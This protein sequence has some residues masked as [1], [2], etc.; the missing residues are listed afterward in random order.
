MK[1]VN[2]T[3][4]SQ[5]ISDFDATK[6]TIQIKKQNLT[7]FKI[8]VAFHKECL[9]YVNGIGGSYIKFL[10]YL[11]SKLEPK[12]I[13]ELGNLTG[14]STLA[15]YDA[16]ERYDACF[17]TIDLERDQRFCPDVMF[18]DPKIQFLFGDVLDVDI[19][20]KVPM[21]IDFLFSDTVH[22]Y[23]QLASEFDV[24]QHLLADRA[25]FAIDD[26]HLNDKGIFWDSLTYDKWDLTVTE[27][28]HLSGWGI[29][30]FERK[31]TLSDEER[32]LRTTEAIAR[33]WKT[34]YSKLIIE[35]EKSK[36]LTIMGRAKRFFVHNHPHIKR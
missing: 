11:I 24:Y 17:T 31:E 19:V 34:R 25:L 10:N 32:R 30:I 9:G 2:K 6:D 21:N 29:F 27:L 28:C 4:I 20:K 36:S 33:I 23:D 3:M 15:I 35:K 14:M 12:N 16:V 7:K 1:K 22:N 5:L 8:D 18:T 26:I 13:V